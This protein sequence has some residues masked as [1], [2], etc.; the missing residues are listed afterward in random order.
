MNN[1]LTVNDE[2]V[3]RMIDNNSAMYYSNQ[4]IIPQNMT[5]RPVNTIKA[6]STKQEEWK[7]WCLEQRFGDGKIA[8]DQKLIYFLAEY[9]MKRGRKLRRN[10]DGVLLL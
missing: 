2:G 9:V 5:H 6:Y 7:K 1:R 8:T 10:T 4:M 3:Q